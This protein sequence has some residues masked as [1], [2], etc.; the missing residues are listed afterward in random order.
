[1]TDKPETIESRARD[2]VARE[3]YCNVGGMVCR[4]AEKEDEQAIEACM[5]VPD[6][7]SAAI[8]EGW[9]HAGKRAG[10]T[11]EDDFVWLNADSEQ[12]DGSARELCEDQRIEPHDREV[13]EHWAVSNW[14]AARLEEQGERVD[15]DFYGLNV[16]SR[17]TTGQ[18]IYADECIEQI[19]ANVLRDYAAMVA[20]HSVAREA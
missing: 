9:K 8:D 11:D 1:M 2:I 19:A 18:A 17:T 12:F 14:L 10:D 5:P 13:F 4:L 3:V 7:E 15:T 20:R 6:Y 16:W